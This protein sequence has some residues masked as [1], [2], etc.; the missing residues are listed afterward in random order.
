MEHHFWRKK[1]RPSREGT[2]WLDVLK[3]LASYRLIDPG[4]EWRLH[5]EWYHRSAMLDVLGRTGNAIELQSLY[6]C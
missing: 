6:L 2:D 4:I 1:L 3:I 5:R